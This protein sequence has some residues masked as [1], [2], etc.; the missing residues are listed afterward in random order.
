VRCSLPRKRLRSRAWESGC[1]NRP[2]IRAGRCLALPASSMT[3]DKGRQKRK[4]E[5]EKNQKGKKEKGK[6]GKKEEKKTE[7][8]RLLQPLDHVT[9][10]RTRGGQLPGTPGAAWLKKA[11]TASRKKGKG[12]RAKRRTGQLERWL[13]LRAGSSSSSTPLLS[14]F[15]LSLMV[16]HQRRDTGFLCSKPSCH[17][18]PLSWFLVC[19]QS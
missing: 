15:S 7:R 1:C 8:Q 9:S 10:V 4:N 2:A 19:F 12:R 11:S 14:P 3:L 16:F 18:L 5:K 13:T 6:K 17:V